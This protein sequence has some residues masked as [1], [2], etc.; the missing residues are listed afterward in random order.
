M[1]HIKVI[2]INEKGGYAHHNGKTFFVANNPNGVPQINRTFI[3]VNIGDATVDTPLK[4]V[5]I[6]DAHEVAQKLADNAAW[7]SKWRSAWDGIQKWAKTH[8]V[9]FS[10][11][12]AQTYP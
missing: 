6:V 3:A 9:D 1:T 12:Q 5:F 7:D 10:K 2:L 4:N 11:I 8:N